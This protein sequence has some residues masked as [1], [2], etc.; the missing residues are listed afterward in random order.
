MKKYGPKHKRPY[1]SSQLGLLVIN[2]VDTWT[3]NSVFVLE[4]DDL[5]FP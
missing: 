2:G 5:N 3:P 4:L 1:Y